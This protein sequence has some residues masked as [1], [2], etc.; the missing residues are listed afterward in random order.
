MSSN[1]PP[2]S[3]AVLAAAIRETAYSRGDR[4]PGKGSVH[5]FD[6]VF[7]VDDTSTRPVG[8]LTASE[9]GELTRAAVQAITD[10]RRA[11]KGLAEGEK[12]AA[13]VVQDIVADVQ[14]FGGDAAAFEARLAEAVRA[15]ARL[16]EAAWVEERARRPLPAA[17]SNTTP[18]AS[19]RPAVETKRAPKRR[20]I[21]VSEP[22]S[23]TYLDSS[24]ERGA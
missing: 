21:N 13:R 22:A 10:L 2:T 17:Q 9:T 1:Q 15:E 5:E 6:A 14:L 3:G 16:A 24:N 8:A 12:H 7:G 20:I 18:A 23:F 11:S 4:A 19:P